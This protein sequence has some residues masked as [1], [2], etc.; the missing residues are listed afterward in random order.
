MRKYSIK[1][2]FGKVCIL[3]SSLLL[4][5]P[6]SAAFYFNKSR[7]VIAIDPNNEEDL[8]QVITVDFKSVCELS[9]CNP[10]GKE[11]DYRFGISSTYVSPSQSGSGNDSRPSLRHNKWMRDNFTSVRYQQKTIPNSGREWSPLFR[12]DRE[13]AAWRP[14][15]VMFKFDKSIL[16]ETPTGQ[17]K[18]FYLV[19]LDDES[20]RFWDALEICLR[21]TDDLKM[22]I[23]HLRDINL[24]EENNS[25]E[26]GHIMPFCVYVSNGSDYT[27]QTTG[28][29]VDNF[30]K[31]NLSNGN[32]TI[33]YNIDYSPSATGNTW[34]TLGPGDALTGTGNSNSDQNCGDTN[35]ARFRIYL[36]EEADKKSGAYSDT[37]TVT[38]MPK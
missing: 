5:E 13:S 1:K 26:N 38:V 8:E 29:H 30:N 2:S 14:A 21:K 24:S 12:I 31:F 34:Q 23:S 18:N 9:G 28:R 37:V 19:G 36:N 25:S 10:G 20:I 4:I 7:E 22:K 15:T 6:V 33:R 32:D 3:L 11:Q 16:N 35:N 27:L 17:C